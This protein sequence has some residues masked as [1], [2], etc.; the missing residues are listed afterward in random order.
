M[1]TPLAFDGAYI[2]DA[3][4]NV[5]DPAEMIRACNAHEQLVA[6][7]KMASVFVSVEGDDE[8]IQQVQEALS[9]AGAA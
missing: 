7:L 1:K 9:A 5:A 8:D 3:D 2:L 6:A 4:G